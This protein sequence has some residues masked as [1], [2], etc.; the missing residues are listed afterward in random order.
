MILQTLSEIDDPNTQDAS[1]QNITQLQKDEDIK[2]KSTKNHNNVAL[3]TS[4][5]SNTNKNTI[6][7]F[8]AEEQPALLLALREK[9]LVLFEGLQTSE[10]KDLNAKLDL[11]INYLQ[12]QVSIIDDILSK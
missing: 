8:I 9:A 3:A 5:A 4:F 7:P 10:M 12:Y 1:T 11:V 2:N 6:R